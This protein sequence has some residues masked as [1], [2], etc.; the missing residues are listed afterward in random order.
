MVSMGSWNGFSPIQRA[1]I[2]CING[3]LSIGRMERNL[4]EFELKIL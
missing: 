4:S 2:N 1:T 3:V